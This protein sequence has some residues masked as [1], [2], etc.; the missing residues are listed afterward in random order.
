MQISW[1]YDDYERPRSVDLDLDDYADGNEA[2]EAI[3]AYL[4]SRDPECFASPTTIHIFSPADV[5][6]T[7]LVEPQWEIYFSA[8][9]E[10]D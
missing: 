10:A 6:G 8:T 3:A 5:A 4:N 2:A 1:A 9:P 7:Y